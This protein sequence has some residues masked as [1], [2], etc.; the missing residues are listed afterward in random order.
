MKYHDPSADYGHY[1][2]LAP[3]PEEFLG[4]Y[5][6]C[7][8]CGSIDFRF[9]LPDWTAVCKKCGAE[10]KLPAG[11]YGKALP[12]IQIIGTA[13]HTILLR[14]DGTVRA[15]G[16]NRYGS[17]DV[18]DWCNIVAISTNTEH[19]VGLCSDGTVVTTGKNMFGRRNVHDWSDVP[20]APG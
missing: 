18:T 20:P 8:N 3:L 19:T 10:P 2:T 16:D 14:P 9:R 12:K 5:A 15:I 6:R 11:V 17:C 4:H 1:P 7:E 13:G